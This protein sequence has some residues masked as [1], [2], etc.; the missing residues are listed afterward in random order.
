MDILLEMLGAAFL[1]ATFCGISCILSSVIVALVFVIALGIERVS[2]RDGKS[3]L[4]DTKR[5]WIMIGAKIMFVL[6]GY[7]SLV[8]MLYIKYKE[9]SWHIF[10]RAFDQAIAIAVGMGLCYFVV[11]LALYLLSDPVG[12][13]ISSRVQLK[14]GA[15]ISDDIKKAGHKIAI[16]IAAVV[17]LYFYVVEFQWI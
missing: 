16:I 9:L 11:F 14:E 3:F 4:Q 7:L 2:R 5:D 15:S 17:M 6:S 1:L 13:Y 10:S 12:A 8:C